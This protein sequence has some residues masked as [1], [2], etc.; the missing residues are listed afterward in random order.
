MRRTGAG[1]LLVALVLAVPLL[2]VPFLAELP[3]DDVQHVSAHQAPTVLGVR[4][5]GTSVQGRA[6]RAFHLGDPSSH[7]TAIILGNMHGDEKAGIQVV[8]ALRSGSPISGVDLW[9]VPTMNPDGVAHD[10]RVN[11]HGVDL[12]RNFGRHWV[13][14]TGANYSGTGPW[15]EPET[16]A[17][18]RF[19][20]DIHPTFIVSFH[21][22]LHA[23]GRAGERLPFVKRLAHGLGLPIKALNCSGVCH[24]T[25]TEWYNAA[26]RGTAVTVEFGSSPKRAYLRGRATRGTLHA[27]F[28][29]R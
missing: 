20:N 10:T 7:R 11:A 13:H 8:D 1:A 22:P 29:S 2:T 24:G 9:V 23:V 4:R 14:L 25:M 6:I 18:R 28:G 16:R 3:D 15:S 17:F 19:A 27:I 26:H 12:N 5:I 21:Q